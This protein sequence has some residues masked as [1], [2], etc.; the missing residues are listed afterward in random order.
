M[1]RRAIESKQRILDAALAIFSQKGFDGARIDEIAKLSQLNKQRI[2]AYFGGKEKLFQACVKTIIAE[3]HEREQ[4]LLSLDSH[5][6]CRL[7]QILIDFYFDYNRS[8]PHFWRLLTWVNISETDSFKLLRNIRKDVFDHLALLYQESQRLGYAP[9][10]V[11]FA[12]Y[13]F[14][15]FAVCFFYFSNR[16]SISQTLQLDFYDPSIL[17]R[18]KTECQQLF[19]NQTASFPNQAEEDN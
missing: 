10:R 19:L 12:G 15:I 4:E 17:E 7:T 18:I 11:S 14:S 2:Y 1:Q 3:M 5:D 8:H 9:L 16:S 6:A 13:M